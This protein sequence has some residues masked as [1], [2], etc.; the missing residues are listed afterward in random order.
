MA[1]LHTAVFLFW[2]FVVSGNL[3]AGAARIEMHHFIT[4]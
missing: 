2:L 4:I 1:R 3:A